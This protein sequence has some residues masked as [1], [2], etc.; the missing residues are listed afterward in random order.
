MFVGFGLRINR[1]GEGRGVKAVV[2]AGIPS[3]GSGS[4]GAVE[5][6][7]EHA[8]VLGAAIGHPGMPDVVVGNGDG[9]RFDGQRHLGFEVH[10]AAHL[11]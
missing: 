5:E 4:G 8:P 11:G 10:V 1:Q 6:K 9:P 2:A 3:G 7:L